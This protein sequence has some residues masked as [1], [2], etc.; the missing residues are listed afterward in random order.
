MQLI[1]KTSRTE[2]WEVTESWGIDYYVY[3]YYDSGD[4][5]VCTSLGMAQS[6]AS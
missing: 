3:G 2:I 6:Y 5:K 4:P 1:Q